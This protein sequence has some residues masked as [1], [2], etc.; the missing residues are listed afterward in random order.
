MAKIDMLGEAAFAAFGSNSSTS[1]R[2]YYSASLRYYYFAI[3][4][5]LSKILLYKS[6][7]LLLYTL[8]VSGIITLHSTGGVSRLA[9]R[10]DP[11][12][13]PLNHRISALA[14]VNRSVGP[15]TRLETGA[16]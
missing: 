2:Y 15:V 8:Q 6:Q 1:L 12:N 9:R 7:V 10:I 11:C 16:A 3:T 4:L 14:S 5:I 13:L